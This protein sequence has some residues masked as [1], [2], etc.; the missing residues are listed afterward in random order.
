MKKILKT[1]SSLIIFS[2]LFSF[3]IQ[4]SFAEDS[5]NDTS[6]VM[7]QLDEMQKT[8][9][10][11]MKND[12]VTL[13]QKNL[14]PIY[15]I[16]TIKFLTFLDST[17]KSKN[18]TNSLVN[19][20]IVRYSQYKQKLLNE[21]NKFRING[22]SGQEGTFGAINS[23]EILTNTYIK[24]AK[25]RM[26]EHIKMSSA[27]HKTALIVEKYQALNDRMRDLNMSIARMYAFF[28]TLENRL[29]GFIR[30]CIV[31]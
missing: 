21:Y 27:N 19:I 15:D 22:D 13:C 17:F 14:V 2:F 4:I 24:L 1:I 12:D 18:S 16:E 25:E 28:K 11:T 8:L 20:A 9:E 7:K 10:E 3:S 29:P 31:K 26:I 6:D 5:G 30:K 23:C